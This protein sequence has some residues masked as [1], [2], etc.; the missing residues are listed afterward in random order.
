MHLFFFFFKSADTLG[1]QSHEC[2]VINHLLLLLLQQYLRYVWQ[3]LEVPQF[4]QISE[5]Q[6]RCRAK[7]SMASVSRDDG[8]CGSFSLDLR[9]ICCAYITQNILV[10]H[11]GQTS[12]RHCN[13]THIHILWIHLETSY[14]SSEDSKD[15]TMLL[16]LQILWHYT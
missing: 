16:S 14:C 9:L 1:D 5:Q 3:V 11:C 6:S 13:T 10:S 12:V 15:T 2:Q 8:W 7:V 4:S